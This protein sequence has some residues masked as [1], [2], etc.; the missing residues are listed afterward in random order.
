M[1]QLGLMALAATAV[2]L[3]RWPHTCSAAARTMAH[4]CTLDTDI[5]YFGYVVGC[6]K[7]YW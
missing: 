7:M 6:S 1:P 3:I 4:G 2:L 5:D